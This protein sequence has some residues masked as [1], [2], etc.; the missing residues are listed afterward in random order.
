MK[1]N[2]IGLRKTKQRDLILKVIASAPGP[3]SVNEISTLLEECEQSTGI[4]TIYRTIN[5]LMDNELIQCVRLH[6]AVQRY[7]LTDIPHHHHFHCT[8]CDKVYDLEGCY[9]HL[10]ESTL[11]EGHLVT[12]HEITFRGL[13]KTCKESLCTDCKETS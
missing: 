6:D 4:A 5:L 7:E 12:S 8:Q 2:H 3:V 9:L 13:C 10:H 1:E 11:K